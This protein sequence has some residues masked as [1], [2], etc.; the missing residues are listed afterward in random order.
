LENKGVALIIIN[1]N[2][3][4]LILTFEPFIIL[5]ILEF[6]LSRTIVVLK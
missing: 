6:N 2:R 1:K 3:K 4:Y 5:F